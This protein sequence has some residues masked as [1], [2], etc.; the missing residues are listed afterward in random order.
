[1]SN[2]QIEMAFACREGNTQDK[3]QCSNQEEFF[4]KFQIDNLKKGTIQHGF[5]L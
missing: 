1:M 2:I 4:S 5:I 3:V